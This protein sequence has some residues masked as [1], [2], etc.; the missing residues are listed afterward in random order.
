MS[1]RADFHHGSDRVIQ[2]LD[3]MAIKMLSRQRWTVDSV[4]EKQKFVALRRI[5]TTAWGGIDED[6]TSTAHP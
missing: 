2:P 1:C 5:E 3:D 4:P 6:V